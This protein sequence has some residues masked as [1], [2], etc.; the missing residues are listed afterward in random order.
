MLLFLPFLRQKFFVFFLSLLTL[1]LHGC[2]GRR[3]VY[4]VLKGE[5]FSSPV[6]VADKL[7]LF[8]KA[9]LK[10]IIVVYDTNLQLIDA[11]K[12]K[13]VDAAY[14]SINDA[15]TLLAKNVADFRIIAI[16]SRIN[17]KPASVLVTYLP[18]LEAP[19][20][21]V[22]RQ[23]IRLIASRSEPAFSI[24]S[25]WVNNKKVLHETSFD[26]G[27][28]KAELISALEE[29]RQNGSISPT[30]AENMARRLVLEERKNY[31]P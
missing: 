19:L 16:A 22:H 30:E 18:D 7:D 11:I 10:P 9:D 4:G 12:N 3:V 26:A 13:K 1:V 25:K 15:L 23:T 20:V 17:F 29:L 8:E 27:L 21:E 31:T 6:I 14:L 28:D 24:I 5:V 2:S